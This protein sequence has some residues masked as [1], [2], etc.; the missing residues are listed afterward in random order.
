[1]KFLRSLFWE[2]V[3]AGLLTVAPSLSQAQQRAVHV[4]IITGASDEPYH[5]WRETTEVV[6]NALQR[7]GRFRVDASEKPQTLTSG[8]LQHYDVVVLNYNGPRW[9]RQAEDAVELFVRSGKGLAAFHQ[10]CYGT[11]FGMEFRDKRWQAG[12][13]GSGWIA[14]PQM[15]GSNWAPENIGHAQRG[16]F[17]VEWEDR[18]HPISRGLPAFFTAYD[19]LYHRITLLPGT[20]VLASAMS[21]VETGG[22]GNREPVVWVKE[23]GK[24]RVFFTTLGH[25]VQAWRRP[26]AINALVRGVEWAATDKVT[27]NLQ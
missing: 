15:I 11:F 2:I 19:E 4:L 10:N 16:E 23:Y 6:R 22:T 8:I 20:R 13:P 12:P 24:G 18:A 21:P 17:A 9:P 26:G 7:T 14:Y 27:V 1:M 5:H 3:A 25:D